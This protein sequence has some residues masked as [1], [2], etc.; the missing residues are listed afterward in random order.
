MRH[1][2]LIPYSASAL[3][4]NTEATFQGTT[5]DARVEWHDLGESFQRNVRFGD[6]HV[7]HTRSWGSCERGIR[8][9]RKAS[10]WISCSW[11]L[12]GVGVLAPNG[13]NGIGSGKRAK[14]L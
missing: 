8:T 14:R 4:A 3:S 13:Q 5:A 12:S 9:E 7:S 6:R 2:I 1:R 11:Q 10:F